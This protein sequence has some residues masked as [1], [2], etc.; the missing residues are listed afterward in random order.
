MTDPNQNP[1][2]PPPGSPQYPPGQQYP[3]GAPAP[4][5]YQ[6]PQPPQRPDDNPDLTPVDWLIAILCS[7]IGCII[8]IIRLIQGKKNGG[9]MLGIS[10]LFVVIWNIVRFII[11]AMNQ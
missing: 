2:Y 3:P 5:G 4:L 8:G 9:K 6:S 10:L 7:G 1:Q 11:V